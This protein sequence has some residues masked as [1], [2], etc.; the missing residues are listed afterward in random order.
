MER[1]EI[2]HRKIP[3]AETALLRR[4]PTP[5]GIDGGL[6]S[7]ESFWSSDREVLAEDFVE[8]R[9]IVWLHTLVQLF[10][11]MSYQLLVQ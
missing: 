2:V 7:V 4:P 9:Q 5:D 8:N 11:R 1:V 3:A 10:V 6:P